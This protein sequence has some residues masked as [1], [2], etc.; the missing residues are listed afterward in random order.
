MK[1]IHRTFDGNGLP[2]L[3]EPIPANSIR[4]FWDGDTLTVY[5]DGDELPQVQ[6]A[7]NVEE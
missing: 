6:V 3:S 2:I 4:N 7:D 1:L 5:E